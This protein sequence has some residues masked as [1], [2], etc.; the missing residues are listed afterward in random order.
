MANTLASSGSAAAALVFESTTFEVVDLNGQQWL[1][2]GQ[3][4]QALG[5]ADET[6]ITKLYARRKGEFT[7]SM[8]QTVN[9][10]VQGQMRETR[11]FSLRGAHLLAMFARTAI[12]ALFRKWVLDILEHH[13]QPEPRTPYAVLPGQTLSEEQADALRAVLTENVKHL[14]KS[15]QATAMIQG[16]SKLK[17]HFKVGYREIP[18][19]EFTEALSIVTRHIV[20]F[21]ETKVLP[22]PEP[23]PTKLSPAMLVSLINGGCLAESAVRDIAMASANYLFR[24]AARSPSGYGDEVRRRIDEKLPMADLH[25]I[26]VAATMEMQLRVHGYDIAQQ[27]RA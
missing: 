25:A 27:G 9:L 15:D 7:D 4:A 18:A 1:K 20:S 10:T 6:A 3:I 23:T 16:W 14:S 8:S 2:S 5:Y 12:A 11:I 24:G 19:S 26:V 17:S 22:A 21:Q 13:S